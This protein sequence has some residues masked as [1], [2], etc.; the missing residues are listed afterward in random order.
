MAGSYYG[1]LPYNP[2][3]NYR[4]GRPPGPR[5]VTR[6]APRTRADP[7]LRAIP[8]MLAT[9]V[10]GFV[11]AHAVNVP[12]WDD[13]EFTEV[14]AGTE[15]F[16]WG[17]VWAPHNEHRLV[18]QK[19]FAFAWGRLTGW[20]VA[21]AT[22]FPALLICGGSL[23]LVRR[24]L[25]QHGDLPAGAQRLLVAA[26]SLWL[27]SLRQHENLT[28][29]FE[30]TW[31]ALF[32]I[33]IAFREVWR[34]FLSEERGGARVAAL[35][36][37]ATFDHAAGLALDLYVIGH[38]LV[39]LLQRRLRTRDTVL[40]L[41]AGLLL[42]AYFIPHEGAFKG[43]ALSGFLTKP[44]RSAAYGLV[45]AGN[46]VAL[47]WPLAVLFSLLS[48][49]LLALALRH[50]LRAD[51]AKA[52][53]DL[54]DERPL[55][56]VGLFMMALVVSGRAGHGIEQA[57]ASRYVT[58]SLLLQWD[59]WTFSFATLRPHLSPR[60]LMTGLWIA[61]CIFLGGW[62]MGLAEGTLVVG[63]RVRALEAF[64]RCASA[65][66]AD[67]RLCPSEHVYPI[68]ETLVRRA[69]ILR[70]KGLCFFQ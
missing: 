3:P 25:A 27:F 46:S 56:V 59:L 28:W 69:R 44:L 39:A 38:A 29:A 23:F 4:G 43:S 54:Y 17:W 16:T 57:S 52:W 2:Q 37:L 18:W 66:S 35:L 53:A 33:V 7:F 60:A 41:T 5:R 19:L 26:I 14:I 68:K 34:T 45:Y 8:A 51:G 10:L 62:S 67:L 6:R 9:F 32:L 11:A 40:A 12:Y 36:V 42:V 20:N 50:R 13:W 63:H 70:E 21:V 15:P 49:C 24:E 31:G 65:P 1:E 22:L 30:L 55:L 64:E 58:L 48:L 47:L 61:L